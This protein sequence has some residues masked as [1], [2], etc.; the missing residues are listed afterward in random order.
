[1]DFA[2]MTMLGKSKISRLIEKQNV[3]GIGSPE[4]FKSTQCENTD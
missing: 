2:P 4:G 1:M 3:Q